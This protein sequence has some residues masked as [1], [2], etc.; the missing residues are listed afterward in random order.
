MAT[1]S[2]P[3]WPEFNDRWCLLY[4]L[5]REPLLAYQQLCSIDPRS[6]RQKLGED[7]KASDL[8]LLLGLVK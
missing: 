7:E 3:E 4:M 5:V 6:L 2:Y 8:A 1:L